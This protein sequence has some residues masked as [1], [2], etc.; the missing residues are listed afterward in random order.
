MAHPT[1]SFFLSL[2]PSLLFILHLFKFIDL[3]STNIP[4]ARG[5][6]PEPGILREE[7]QHLP[8]RSSLSS[9]GDK[10][11]QD[12]WSDR[13]V[14]P[15]R[16]QCNT[17][18]GMEPGQSQDIRESTG[19]DMAK[20]MATLEAEVT[21]QVKVLDHSPHQS[22]TSM[23]STSSCLL[24]PPLAPALFDITTSHHCILLLVS[25]VPI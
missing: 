16:S 5:F 10:E 8:S 15:G 25:M 12:F 2:L 11:T 7:I 20:G 22:I 4:G 3:L 17:F 9:W 6:V 13:M 24:Y 19:A 23:D 18:R 1:S 21:A 14:F